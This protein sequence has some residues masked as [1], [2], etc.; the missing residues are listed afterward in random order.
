MAELDETLDGSGAE[1][2]IKDL[3][4]KVKT[5]SEERDAEKTARET[6][7]A[8]KAEAERERD[9]YSGFSDVVSVNPAAKDHKDEILAKVKGGYTVQDATFAVLG[10]AGKLGQQ[11]V[12]RATAA[13]G[14]ADI[15]VNREG[16][17]TIG[18]MTQ[19]ERREALM[20]NEGDLVDILSPRTLNR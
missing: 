15:Q 14:S 9:F 4:G 10:A 16:T 12:E 20:A 13:G 19:A 7:E 6:A 18:E 17:K 1:A 5:A 3:S 11:T 8:G 2:R